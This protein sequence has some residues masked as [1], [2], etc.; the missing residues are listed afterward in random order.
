MKEE[1]KSKIKKGL[2]T[3]EATILAL[4]ASVQRID[5]YNMINE[6]LKKMNDHKIITEALHP[7]DVKEKSNFGFE[8]PENNYH[9]K[10]MNSLHDIFENTEHISEKDFSKQDSLIDRCQNII[11]NPK[12]ENIIQRFKDKNLRPSYCA[13]Y[14]FSKLK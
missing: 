10:V 1:T 6:M 14:I 4:N 9:R 3:A 13:E 8:I 7:L 12:V 2:G 5:C 11:R